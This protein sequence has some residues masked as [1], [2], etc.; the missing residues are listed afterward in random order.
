MRRRAMATALMKKHARTFFHVKFRQVQRYTDSGSCFCPAEEA[1]TKTVQN[2]CLFTKEGNRLC[3]TAEAHAL[4]TRHAAL[5]ILPQ[6]SKKKKK[7][8]EALV[9]LNGLL[10]NLLFL[11]FDTHTIPST[12][13][14]ML[15]LV[16][17]RRSSPCLS[18]AT[19]WAKDGSARKLYS[20]RT[21]HAA[22]NTVPEA[23]NYYRR[24]RCFIYYL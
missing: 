18:Y 13:F 15:K 5:A 19:L 12:V 2:V 23:D 6:I 11:H 14:F 8:H 24:S 10:A 7:M 9:L 3:R 20:Q 1:T 21:R 16:F 22:S 4:K 17:A